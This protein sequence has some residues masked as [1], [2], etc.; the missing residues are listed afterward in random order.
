MSNA[1]DYSAIERLRDGTTIEIR[2]LRPDDREDMLAAIGRTSAQSLQRRF[3]VPKRGFSEQE[4][5]FFMNIDFDD[6]VALIARI[7]ENGRPVIAGGGRYIMTQPGQAELAFVVIDAFQ[8]KGIAKALLRHLIA[9]AREARLQELTAEVLPENAA[10]LKVFSG[11]GFRAA[12]S[13]DPQLRH[14]VLRLT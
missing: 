8:G 14:L 9:I 6:H 7:D 2:A 4:V 12:A 3:F 5:S 11:L 10:M 1:I 13:R